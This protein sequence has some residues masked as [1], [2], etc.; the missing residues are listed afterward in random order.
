MATGSA[1]NAGNNQSED[2]YGNRTEGKEGESE[3]DKNKF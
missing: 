1:K 3:G 2:E